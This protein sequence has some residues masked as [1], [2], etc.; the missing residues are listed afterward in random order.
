MQQHRYKIL[1]ILAPLLCQ[2]PYP[3][4]HSFQ[5]KVQT[6]ERH[7]E[8]ASRSHA[9]FV[10]AGPRRGLPSPLFSMDFLLFETKACLWDRANHVSLWRVDGEGAS[11]YPR[12]G[13]GGGGGWGWGHF[14]GIFLE[15]QA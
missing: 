7:S 5:D 12:R 13:G 1:V 11:R 6:P 9:L 8:G 4:P 15:S 3:Q 10:S 14:T 2:C